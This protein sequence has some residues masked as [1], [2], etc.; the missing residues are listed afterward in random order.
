MAIVY[1]KT[2]ARFDD[3]I[4]IEA[5]EALLTWLSAHPKAKIDLSSC[6]HLHAAVLQVLMA[7]RVTVSRW[8]REERLKAWLNSALQS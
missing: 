3:T 2:V 5:A 4:A 6:S 7:A 8:P 1:K